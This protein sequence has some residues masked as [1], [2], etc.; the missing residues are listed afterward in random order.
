MKKLLFYGVVFEILACTSCCAMESRAVEQVL[1]DVEKARE[2]M[3]VRV[4]GMEESKKS[5][6]TMEVSHADF[7]KQTNDLKGQ[8]DKKNAKICCFSS[9]VCPCCCPCFSLAAL[10]F[11]IRSKTY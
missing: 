8:F 4:H 10:F 7:I 6:E 1:K 9:V 11:Y 3:Q 2:I 5:Q